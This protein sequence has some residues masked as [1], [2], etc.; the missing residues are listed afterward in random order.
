MFLQSSDPR[1][2]ELDIISLLLLAVGLSMDVFSVSA[3][4][5]CGMGKVGRNQM[6]RLAFFFGAFHV[7]MPVIGWY[8]GD[9]VAELIAGYDHWLAFLLL[10]FVGGRMLFEGIRGDEGVDPSRILQLRSLIVFSLAVSIDSIAIGLSFGLSGVPILFPSLLIG[11]TAFVF[12]YI[13]VMVGCKTGEWIG[14]WSEIAG[15]LVLLLI[16]LRILL[17]HIW[18]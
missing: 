15:G 10:A 1:M 14:R 7:F 2:A 18:M 16:G 9:R 6:L 5:G 12:T 4:T 17:S 3:A 13:G 8:A 11:A